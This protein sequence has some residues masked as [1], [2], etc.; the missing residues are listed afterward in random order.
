VVKHNPSVQQAKP[1][2]VKRASVTQRVQPAAS[3]P[4]Q[5]VANISS[6]LAVSDVSGDQA[7]S[8]VSRDLMVT[9][10]QSESENEDDKAMDI[11]KD[12]KS[13][14][15]EG[16]VVVLEGRYPKADEKIPVKDIWKRVPG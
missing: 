6:D 14:D 15:T 10:T 12:S 16:E 7:I 9:N 4:L 13:D 1:D 3:A 2:V 5:S 11:S 8:D